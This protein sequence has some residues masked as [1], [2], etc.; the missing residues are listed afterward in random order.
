M[1][2]TPIAR[3]R[4][5][6]VAVGSIAALALL[7]AGAFSMSQASA[8]ASEGAAPTAPSSATAPASTRALTAALQAAVAE[9][10]DG[11]MSGFEGF[12][13]YADAWQT[14]DPLV[15]DVSRD[16]F[17]GSFS[18]APADDSGAALVSV[19]LTDKAS[20][21]Y[22]Q[23]TAEQNL[24]ECD[25]FKQDCE[26]TTLPDGSLLRTYATYGIASNGGPQDYEMWHV[27]R[28]VGDAVVAVTATNG[29]N[30]TRSGIEVTR[31]H[32]ALSVE[33]LTEI[34]S[35]SWWGYELPQE[36]A[37][38]GAALASFHEEDSIID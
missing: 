12:H 18:F 19:N 30:L 38:A 36:F 14:H 7:G 35:R 13:T 6:A 28:I 5:R 27:E 21:D 32:P 22:N 37:D 11:S 25:D 10:A 26:V 3:T 8:D 24:S 20:W 4:H 17:M 31:T 16:A 15:D 2:S 29:G 23:K 34:V 9:V 33:Q 1:P